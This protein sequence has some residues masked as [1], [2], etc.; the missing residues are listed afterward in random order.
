M[1]KPSLN[2]YYFIRVD[3]SPGECGFVYDACL[4]EAVLLGHCAR[5]SVTRGGMKNFDMSAG[6]TG[7]VP[8]SRL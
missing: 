4:D 2:R 5:V 1:I 3:R 7:P 8:V 6:S